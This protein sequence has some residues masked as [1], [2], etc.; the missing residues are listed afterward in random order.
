MQTD[1]LIIGQGLAGSLLAWELMQRGCHVIVVDNGKENASLVAS[2]IINP[3]M[4]M[5]FVKTADVETLLPV[6]L[7]SYNQMSA[8]FGQ[9]FYRDMPMFR[10]F[11]DEAELNHCKTRQEQPE[12]APYLG[13]LASSSQEIAQF[14]TPFGF[15]GQHQAGHLLT[16]PLLT[17][18][19]QFL[20]ERNAYRLAAVDYRVIQMDGLVRWQDI[21]TKQVIFCEGHNG[22][23]NPWFSWLPFQPAK[24]EILTLSHQAE[25]P[26]ALLNY[27][28]WLLPLT[29]DKVR[30]GATFDRE[31]IDTLP[32]EQ[33]K[34][35]LLNT[36]KSYS[37]R[38]AQSTIVNH[39]AGIR[40]CTADKAPFI[41]KHPHD[42]RI[43]IFNGFGAKGGLQIPWYSQRFAD[44][45]IR[46]IPLPTCCDIQRFESARFPG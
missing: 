5:R 2:G 1:F 20:I 42:G 10:I 33:G 14:S 34:Q 11:R 37:P 38:L 23:H 16:V 19:K 22:R 32:S 30:I 8:F 41:G 29:P 6:A 7:C 21:T 43:A 45:L 44:Y 26:D 18:V 39:Q 12:Y 9:R 24:G 27:G 31:Q 40:S 35:T 17:Q 3:I 15:I 13:D 25:L 28:N 4:G 46:N 36:L